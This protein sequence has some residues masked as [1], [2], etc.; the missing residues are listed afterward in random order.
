MASTAKPYYSVSLQSSILNTQ[1]EHT[2][3]SGWVQ[4]TVPTAGLLGLGKTDQDSLPLQVALTEP[5]G[6][7]MNTMPPLNY[8]AA[9]FEP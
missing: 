1:E 6:R 9:T 8:V 5:Q 4:P 3:D 2:A 7:E